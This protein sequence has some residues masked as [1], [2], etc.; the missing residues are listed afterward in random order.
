[1]KTRQIHVRGERSDHGACSKQPS[2]NMNIDGVGIR[3]RFKGNV[4]FFLFFQQ[5]G[6]LYRSLVQDRSKED[7]SWWQGPHKLSKQV[8][9]DKISKLVCAWLDMV[10]RSEANA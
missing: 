6:A 2:E 4:H 7:G 10:L 1:M 3:N 9:C 8:Y 5:R